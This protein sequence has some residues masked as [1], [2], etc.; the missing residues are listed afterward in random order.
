MS[1]FIKIMFLSLGFIFLG[2][3]SRAE[4]D[5]QYVNLARVSLDEREKLLHQLLE[6]CKKRLSDQDR[7]FL[8][9][10]KCKHFKERLKNLD[11]IGLF[12]GDIIALRHNQVVGFCHYFRC[13]IYNF[14][15]TQDARGS[16]LASSFMNYVIHK[17]IR[18]C[19]QVSL[20]VHR[21]NSR[22]IG[23]YKKNGFRKTDFS[24]NYYVFAKDR[25]LYGLDPN[26]LKMFLGN[27]N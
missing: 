24:D 23:F 4:S 16:G 17:A 20:A 19:G 18:N 7:A 15:V 1:K 22:A 27:I 9:N 11:E 12:K 3:I 10:E 14:F 21:E 25:P 5:V 2:S 26:I 8:E 13:H 6:A